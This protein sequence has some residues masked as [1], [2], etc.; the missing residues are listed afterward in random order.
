MAS[1]SSSRFPL[2]YVIMAFNMLVYAYTSFLSGDIITTSQDVIWRY[3]QVNLL[4]LEHGYVW[5]LFTAIFVHANIVHLVGNMFFLL[6]FGL[7]AE[8]LFSIRQ[9]GAIY[10]LSGIAGNLT[11]L[12]LGPGIVSVGASGAVFGVFGACAIYIRRAVGQ[13]IVGALFLSFL[14]LIMGADARVNIVA[15]LGGLVTGLLA[16]YLL[17]SMRRQNVAYE[18]C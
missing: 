4:V 2:T 16:G 18:Y 13:S 5:Q 3:G 12:L 8:E 1:W 10:L 14:L 17:A 9:Y 7:R 6:I 11:T 15:H